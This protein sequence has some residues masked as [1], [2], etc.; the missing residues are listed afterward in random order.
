MSIVYVRFPLGGQ[1]GDGHAGASWEGGRRAPLLERLLA[2]AY[3]QTA[4]TDWREDAYRCVTGA[5]DRPPAPA[6]AAL[7]AHAGRV[8]APWVAVATPVS[9]VAAM[10]T[11]RLAPRGCLRLSGADAREL[12]A[13]FNKV[14]LAGGQRLFAADDGSLFCSFDAPLAVDTQDPVKL[15]GGE[16]GSSLP[17]GPDGARLRGL[18]SEIEMWLYEH[19]LNAQRTARAELPISALWLW[20]GGTTL[21]ELVPLPA[22]VAGRDPLF[23][24]WSTQSVAQPG[25]GSGIV[26]LEAA[27][28][29]A[30]W[31]DAEALWLA[32]ALDALAEG[33][34]GSLE[35]SAGAARYSLSARWP[36]RWWRGS[37]PWW[38]SFV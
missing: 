8:A 22:W 2:H 17:V 24:A 15:L 26:V 25:E 18:M 37:R 10:T 7:Y 6:A 1:H 20:G 34:I 35:L 13:D 23:S 21:A 33:R 38:E 31:S 36:W 5:T 30:A 29:E 14:F 32:P 9:Y 4:V 3:R 12:A 19:A 11:V 28:G 16:I 27:P